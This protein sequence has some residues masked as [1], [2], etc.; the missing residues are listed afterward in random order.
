MPLCKAILNISLKHIG[1]KHEPSYIQKCKGHN[2]SGPGPH[3][4]GHGYEYTLVSDG[5]K[6]QYCIIMGGIF[7]GDSGLR[8]AKIQGDR[9][10][11][12]Q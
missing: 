9:N 10:K 8:Q 4:G 3:K 2:G 12:N 11:P 6:E 5:L 7:K 1:G